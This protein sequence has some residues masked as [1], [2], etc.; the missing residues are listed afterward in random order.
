MCVCVCFIDRHSLGFTDRQ[1]SVQEGEVHFRLSDMKQ[2]S[3]TVGH[4]LNDRRRGHPTLQSG[5]ETEKM[6]FILL[7]G[8]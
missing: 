2:Q 3:Q 8:G 7:T 4:D 5:G 6:S 1:V